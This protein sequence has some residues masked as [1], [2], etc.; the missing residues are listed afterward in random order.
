MKTPS[1]LLFALTVSAMAAVP[2]E[3]SRKAAEWMQSPE[4][5]KRDAAYRS[6]M[7]L[8]TDAM[9]DYQK[10][11]EAARKFHN[12]QIDR[13]CTGYR[14]QSNPYLKH[15]PL[16]AEL[17]AERERVLPLIRT[18]WK[19]EPRKIEELREAMEELAELNDKTR[20]AARAD[21]KDFDARLD[22]H[23]AALAE[24]HR[25][26]QRFEEEP[27]ELDDDE[28]RAL[29][30]EEQLEASHFQELRERFLQTRKEITQLAEVEKANESAGRWADGSMRDFAATLN[31]NRSLLG[32]LPLKL[33]EKLSDAAKGHSS[34]MARLGFF[35]HESPVPGKKSPWD[36]ARVAGF[37]GNASGENIFMGSTSPQAAYDAWFASD[38]HRFIMMSEGPN[39]LGV[40]PVGSHWTMMTGNHP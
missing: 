11:L 27:E 32:L 13:L 5:A 14:G 7:Q 37:Q 40:G 24:I 8:G 12:Q 17:D 2:A 28:L 39:V 10:A 3:F 35:A 9:P 34:D 38:G 31:I 29:V 16:A 18:D 23:L 6:W 20:K 33:E 1:L 4:A 26:S 25:E 36:R 19:K 22:G 21:T 15:E 30:L